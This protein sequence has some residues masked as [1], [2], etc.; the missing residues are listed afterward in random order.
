MLLE[1]EEMAIRLAGAA[2]WNR[3]I[4]FFDVTSQLHDNIFQVSPTFRFG[5]IVTDPD[6]NKFVDCAITAS[7]DYL[8]TEDRHFH[9]L[10]G[11]GYRPQVISPQTF[12]DKFLA[13]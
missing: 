4:E 11:S 2:Y 9:V 8:V 7:S 5:L 3:I 6:D 1:Y 12:I 13:P 10:A